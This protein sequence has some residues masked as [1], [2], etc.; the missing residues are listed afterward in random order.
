MA[1]EMFLDIDSVLGESQVNDFENK[2][3]IFSFSLGASNPTSV[4]TGW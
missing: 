3:D 4:G 1:V 2:M